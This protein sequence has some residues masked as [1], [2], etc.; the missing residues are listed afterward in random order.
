M[1]TYR[2][3]RTIFYQGRRHIVF[4][5]KTMHTVRTFQWF[6]TEV[7]HRVIYDIASFYRNVL[8]AAAGSSG[9]RRDGHGLPAPSRPAPGTCP[10]LP[11]LGSQY[12]CPAEAQ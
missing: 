6:E 3:R 10:A 12:G 11:G 4:T 7:P 8:S 9:D 1:G 2:H 5:G